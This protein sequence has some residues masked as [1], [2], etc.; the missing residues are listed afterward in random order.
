MKTVLKW[1]VRAVAAIF[2]VILLLIGTVYFRGMSVMKGFPE[3]AEPTLAIS[4]DSASVAHGA[5]LVRTHVCIDCHGSDLGR[6]IIVDDAPFLIVA[7]NLTRG[8]GGVAAA[9][10]DAKWIRAVR[11][12]IGVDGRALMV[13]PSEGYHNLSDEEASD[14]VAYVR[15]V[16][17]VDRQLPASG[18]DALF[19]IAAGAGV[20]RPAAADIDRLGPR[21]SMPE[22]GPTAEWGFYRT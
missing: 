17:P 19:N 8:D 16:E 18:P 12:G 22:M 5:Y 15:Q 4:G 7:P 20:F 2:V 13:M 11:G 21:P 1:M 3:Y 14:L 10:D 6:A 9:M